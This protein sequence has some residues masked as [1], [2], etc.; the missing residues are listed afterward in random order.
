MELQ[1]QYK[2]IKTEDYTIEKIITESSNNSFNN[3]KKYGFIDSD[4]DSEDSNGSINDDEPTII[5][6]KNQEDVK[7]FYINNLKEI[8]KGRGPNKRSP[9]EQGY[10]LTTLGKY[11]DKTR[12]RTTTDIYNHR[13]WNLNNTHKYTFFPCY[14]DINN[15]DTLEWWF[16]TKENIPVAVLDKLNVVNTFNDYIIPSKK[17]FEYTFYNNDKL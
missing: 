10:Y 2:L 1:K 8:F 15:K 6:F 11:V 4:E 13:K 3:P 12:V 9:D 7:K 14:K 16:I 5:R 17:I